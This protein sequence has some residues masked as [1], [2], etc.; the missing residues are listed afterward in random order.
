MPQQ[1][2]QLSPHFW[3]SEFLHSETATRCGLRNDPGPSQLANL[4]RT[5]N[6]A[7]EAR[8]YL[9]NVEITALSG[10]R[11]WIVNA[12]VKKI[13]T[14][15]QVP[16][17]GTRPDLVKACQADTSAHIDG[18]ALD[19]I[20]PKFGTPREIVA[21]L[22][23]SPLQFDQLIFEGTWVHLGIAPLNTPPRREVLTAV[24]K[25]GQKT[26]YLRGLQ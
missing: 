17:L 22:A 19:F 15:E 9:H 12:V 5:A 13:I 10:L 16:S 20:A 26:D 14:P 6:V 1:D 7:E 21:R 4:K 2:V 23:D 25:P 24:F 8:G 3:L 11:T 18:R